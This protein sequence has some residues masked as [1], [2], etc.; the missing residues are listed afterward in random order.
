MPGRGTSGPALPA[1]PVARL[2]DLSR[3]VSRVG[4][5]PWTG[6]D[7]VEAAYLSHLAAR[8]AP[9]WALVRIG[10]GS[11]LIGPDGV[12]ALAGRL[13]GHAAWGPAGPTARLR[14]RTLPARARAEADIRRLACAHA[15]DGRLAAMLARHLPETTHAFN[16]GHANL[17]E[18]TLTALAGV[19]GL[20]L[21]VRVHDTIPLDHPEFCRPETARAMRARLE[22]AARHA[23]RLIAVSGATAARLRHHLGARCPPV[24]VAHPGVDTVPPRPGAM[25]AH[26]PPAR[27]YF[28]TVGTIEAR[29]NHALLLDLWQALARDHHGAPPALVIAGSRGWRCDDVLARLDAR[30]PGVIEA[31]GLSDGALAAL[32][33]GARA[34]LFPS[35]AEGFGMPPIEALAL[36]VPSVV[37][38]LAVYGETLADRV[39]YASPDAPYDWRVTTD[40][41]L[42]SEDSFDQA[43]APRAG[44]GWAAHFG[45]VLDGIETTPAMRGHRPRRRRE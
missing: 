3:L 43:R 25:P 8:P 31:P 30:P 1:E 38:P 19:P 24:T 33:G 7:R 5:G 6:I 35:R 32:V 44:P 41:L 23:G 36:G 2:L 17:T 10:G 28:V 12:R 18:S 42:N 45:Q 4:R 39:I 34:M 20:S 21:S 26:L 16:V 14:R 40:R 37:P 13:A 22:A 27:P 9:L 15:R 11:A 29:K